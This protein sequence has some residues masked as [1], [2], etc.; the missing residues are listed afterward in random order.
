MGLLS[1]RPH[2]HPIDPAW[3]HLVRE[4]NGCLEW[5]GDRFSNGYARIKIDGREYGL[6]RLLLLGKLPP[7]E[8]RRFAC[9]TC[10]NRRCVN[11]EHLYE[12]DFAANAKDRSRSPLSLKGSGNG[13]AKLTEGDVILLRALAEVAPTRYLSQFFSITTGSVR[14][15]VRG[16]TWSHV[17]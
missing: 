11:T 5:I 16:K 9:H 13:H 4:V 15:V 3:E 7:E 12:G 6:H 8:R 10:D 2:A 1:S 14:K 17:S